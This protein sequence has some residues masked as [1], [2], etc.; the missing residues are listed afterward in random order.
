MPK[1]LCT[2]VKLIGPEPS[3]VREPSRHRVAV[4][5]TGLVAAL[6]ICLSTLGGATRLAAADYSEVEAKY[7]AGEYQEAKQIAAAQVEEGIW[8]ER[9][10]RLLIRCQLA[11]GDYAAAK[12]TYEAAIRRYPTSLTLRMLGL[13]I[14]R[15]N[16]LKLEASEARGQILQLLQTSI[17][18][19]ASRDNLIAAGRYFAA[20]GE[21]AKKVLNVF[22]DRV[23]DAGRSTHV[24]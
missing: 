13:D 15:L 1:P 2:P 5:R 17:S 8:N 19:F 9:W 10:P 14:L 3:I 18:R 22:F 16:G 4:T 20:Q 23:R 12:E 6:V 11:T 24:V 21:D 7:L